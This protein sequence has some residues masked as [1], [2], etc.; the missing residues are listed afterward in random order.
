MIRVG[1]RIKVSFQGD[2]IIG[3]VLDISPTRIT[4]YEEITYLSY[5]NH[6]RAGRV[7]F[8]PNNLIFTQ[9]ILNYS[10]AGLKT[11]WDTIDIVVTFD[12]DHK[13]AAHIIREIARRYSKGYTELTRKQ[14]G[15]LRDRYSVKHTNVDP[16]VFIFIEPYGIKISMWYLTNSFATL[17]LKSTI[18]AEIIDELK[19][20]QGIKIA[21]PTQTVAIE[22][23]N[24]SSSPIE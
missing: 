15:K 22:Q 2:E 8:V 19:N 16:R 13:K 7:I 9:V 11:V 21:Y 20:E 12:S 5:T 1:D 3:D 4:L 23:K 6:K 17:T 24:I 10:H 18:S 14:F